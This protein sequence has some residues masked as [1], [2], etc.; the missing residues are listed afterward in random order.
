MVGSSSMA[1][2]TGIHCIPNRGNEIILAISASRFYPK[3]RAQ[4]RIKLVAEG[5]PGG[6]GIHVAGEMRPSNRKMSRFPAILL[7]SA[8][9]GTSSALL[10]LRI[11]EQRNV[12]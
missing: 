6:N 3:S 9:I 11:L 7:V 12:S 2:S 10:L 1:S 4:E 5:A 8:M